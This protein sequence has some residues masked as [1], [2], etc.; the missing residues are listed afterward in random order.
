MRNRDALLGAYVAG[1]S[2]VHRAPLAVKAAAVVVLSILTLALAALPATAAAAVLTAAAYA[3]AGLMREL[4]RP[5]AVMWPVLV[6]IAAVQLWTVDAAAAVVTAGNILVCVAAARLLILTVPVP[7]LLDGVVALVRPLRVF[8]AD[9][10][11]F[12]LALALMIRSLPYL[13]GSAADVR[14]SAKAR[15]L[16][17]NLRAQAVP[18]VIRAVAYAQQTGDALA[19]RGIGEPGGAE[20][21]EADPDVA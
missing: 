1:S 13:L 14:G 15:G 9:P 11:R 7:E 6:L 8:G 17:R 21:D 2:A 10:E 19:A 20:P 3:A 12:G 16:E 4:P 18:V 5:L